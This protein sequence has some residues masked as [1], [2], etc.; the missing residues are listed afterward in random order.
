MLTAQELHF[1]YYTNSSFLASRLKRKPNTN[2]QNLEIVSHSA[3]RLGTVPE[4]C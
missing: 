2:L 1:T 3:S 4:K